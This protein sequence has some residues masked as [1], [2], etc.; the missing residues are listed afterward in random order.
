MFFCL[1]DAAARKEPK[2]LEESEK[3]AILL[4]LEAAGGNK[5]KVAR[6]LEI[7]RKTLHKKLEKY[8]AKI[9]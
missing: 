9:S 2:S 6:T 8:G 3:E 4:A 7:I 5:S 1:V